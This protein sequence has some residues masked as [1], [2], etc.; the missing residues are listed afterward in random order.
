MEQETIL[1]EILHV[2]NIHSELVEKKFD[3]MNSKMNNMGAR[4][5]T[6]E[7]KMD[8]MESRMDSMESKMDNLESRM[9]NLESKMEKGFERLGK[10]VDGIKVELTET[11]E[12][13]DYLLSKTT[14]HEKK[15][16]KLSKY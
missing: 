16:R 5:D 3:E 13:T 11:Q 1:K 15:L 6:M 12:T 8:S 7:S 4:M 2:L 10:K 9:D 14:Q